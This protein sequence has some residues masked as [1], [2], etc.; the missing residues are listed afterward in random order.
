MSNMGFG[1]WCECDTRSCYVA[2]KLRYTKE[3]FEKEIAIE[4]DGCYE[5]GETK[6][7]YARWYPV[8]PEGIDRE[9]GTYAFCEPNRGSF[10]VWVADVK[11]LREGK[12]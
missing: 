9:G 2:P 7:L 5:L 4:V 6:E 12:S 10:P 3:E 11:P 1:I 8:A